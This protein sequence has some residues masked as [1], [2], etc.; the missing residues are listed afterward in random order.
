LS[1]GTLSTNGNASIGGHLTAASANISTLSTFDLTIAGTTFDNI[2]DGKQDK[3]TAGSGITIDASNVITSTGGTTI[4]STTD[5]FLM[6]YPGSNHIL[7]QMGQNY[8]L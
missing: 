6:Y 8:L 1:S 2:I 5:L 4:D 3:L 7:G